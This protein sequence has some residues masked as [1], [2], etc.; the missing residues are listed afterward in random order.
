[1]TKFFNFR[2]VFYDFAARL[3][4]HNH[5]SI[6]CSAGNAWNFDDQVCEEKT[7]FYQKFLT[8]E[9]LILKTEDIFMNLSRMLYNHKYVTKSL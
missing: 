3:N 8:R 4:V 2:F 6:K 1:M 7:E 5:V 9:Y